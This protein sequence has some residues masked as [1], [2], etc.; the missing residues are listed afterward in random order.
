MG[1]GGHRCD[2]VRCSSYAYLHD[3]WAVDVARVATGRLDM[4][5]Q[6]A[7]GS[8]SIN[9]PGVYLPGGGSAEAAVVWPGGRQNSVAWYTMPWYQ[10]VL[11]RPQAR[12]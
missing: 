6:F 11:H 7:G 1:G 12:F 9:R 3:L 5:M 8:S 4:V 10:R 2:G